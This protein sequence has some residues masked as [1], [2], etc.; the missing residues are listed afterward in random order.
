MRECYLIFSCSDR[1]EKLRHFWHMAT[2]PKHEKAY[3]NQLISGEFS[4]FTCWTGNVTCSPRAVSECLHQGSA[5][6]PRWTMPSLEQW[7]NDPGYTDVFLV[8]VLYYQNYRVSQFNLHLWPHVH[9]ML[10]SV[11]C[12]V[13]PTCCELEVLLL[14][15]MSPLASAPAL[16]TYHNKTRITEYMKYNVIHVNTCKAHGLPKENAILGHNNC[17]ARGGGI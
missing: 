17:I 14:L 1:P 16:I 9:V 4:Q 3:A 15:W 13:L 2:H 12:N 11:V 8:F 6:V 7:I 5:L 10:G